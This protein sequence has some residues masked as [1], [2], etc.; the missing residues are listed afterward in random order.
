M[1]G[2]VAACSPS[3]AGGAVPPSALPASAAPVAAATSTAGVPS[4]A[5]LPVL[6][7]F[8]TVKVGPRAGQ[9]LIDPRSH[10]AYVINANDADNVVVS[11]GVT[12]HSSS[13]RPGSVSVINPRSHRVVASI[14]LPPQVGGAALDPGTHQLWAATYWKSTVTVIDTRTNRVS[15]TLHMRGFGPSAV[16]VDPSTHTVYV[17]DRFAGV[18]AIDGRTHKLLATIHIP[19]ADALAV[20]ATRHRLY[21]TDGGI[22]HLLTLD[23]RTNKVVSRTTI[24][25]NAGPITLSTGGDV[26]YVED[27]GSFG[28]AATPPWIVIVNARTGRVSARVQLAFLAE[29]ALDPRTRTLYV[30]VYGSTELLALKGARLQPVA[31]LP[32]PRATFPGSLTFNGNT[33]NL[34]AT[35]NDS[36][37]LFR[38]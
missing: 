28:K 19:E 30:R 13:T 6:V 33:G 20:D 10:V 38:P 11:G 32:E 7:P 4:A 26:V 31:T 21:V 12:S 17:S 25:T 8:A 24:G 29:L 37:K 16:T 14:P 23:T 3:R 27:G 34:Y 15:A 5:A 35:D 22:G 9:V 1:V 18:Y 2:A 36:L